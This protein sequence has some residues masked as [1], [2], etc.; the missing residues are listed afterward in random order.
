MARLFR[1]LKVNE[2]DG[3]VYLTLYNRDGSAALRDVSV[4][5][6]SPVVQPGDNW[7]AAAANLLLRL[8]E[9]GRPQL[10]LTPESIGAAAAGDGVNGYAHQKNGGV[11]ALTGTGDNIRFVAAADFGAG[12]S[13]TVNGVPCTARTPGGDGLWPGF[14]RAGAVVVCYRAG[15]TLT[16]NGGGLP[17][18]EAAK[19]APENIKTGVSITANGRTVTGS[20]TEDANAQAGQMLAG[21]TAYV[22]GQRVTGTMP[23]RGN[24]QYG[25]GVGFGGDYVAINNIPEGYYRK[26]GMDWAPEARIAKSALVSAIGLNAG[27]LRQGVNVLGVQGTLESRITVASVGYGRILSYEVGDDK[28]PMLQVAASSGWADPA[29]GVLGPTGIHGY[30]F[31]TENAVKWQCRVSGQYTIVPYGQ[32]TINLSGQRWLNAG[33]WVIMTMADTTDIYWRDSKSGGFC[34]SRHP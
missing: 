14:F 10:A 17:A 23:D 30:G 21:A 5:V 31:L 32:G 27:D 9:E 26:N 25:T 22:R 8:D 11:H 16:F 12:D 1:D 2:R 6:S 28:H 29:H 19:L 20:F 15:N 13:F 18:A 34:V 3:K 4:Q 33:D 24:A 7:S